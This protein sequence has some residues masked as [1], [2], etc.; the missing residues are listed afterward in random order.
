MRFSSVSAWF[1]AGRSITNPGAFQRSLLITL[2]AQFHHLLN[3]SSLF[4]LLDRLFADRNYRPP[5]WT[6]GTVTENNSEKTKT[7]EQSRRL[8]QFCFDDQFLNRVLV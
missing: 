2:G 4:H 5:R 1:S 8:M 3:I 7:G 6:D